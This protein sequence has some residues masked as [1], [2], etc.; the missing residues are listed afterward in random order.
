M[1]PRARRIMVTGAAKGIGEAIVRAC[2]EQGW[3]VLATD[4]D[5]TALQTLED[6]R[7][8]VTPVALDV[9]S[10]ER[11]EQ[12]VASFEASSGPLHALVN[13]AGICPA[14]RSEALSLSDE[15]DAIEVNLMGVIHGVR[16]LRPRFLER[17][18]GHIVTIASMAAFAPSPELAAYCASKH[19]VRAY[20]HSCALE[21][22]HS[23]IR[24]TV[25]YP[26]LVETPMVRKIRRDRAA[27]VI[28]SERPMSPVAV[29]RAV[30]E[31]L[32]RGPAEVFLPD[33]R[34]RALRF[35]GLL[36]GLLRRGMDAAEQRGR[37]NFDEEP[38]GDG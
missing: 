27:S 13:N 10:P 9:R 11:W 35:F 23:P 8:N 15:R 14:G 20:S 24:Y 12:V 25:V 31:A 38:H 21:D 17:R 16:T 32:E 37:S 36:P 30:T 22:R 34:G 4:V 3:E 19:A 6:E 2:V 33:L 1:S 29:A 7:P 28:F 26:G 18:S 5:V